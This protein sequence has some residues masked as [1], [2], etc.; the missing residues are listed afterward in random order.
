MSLK[1]VEVDK[2]K[3]QNTS[4]LQKL[5]EWPDNGRFWSRMYSLNGAVLLPFYRLVRRE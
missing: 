5:G 3:R 2:T 4:P 1:V